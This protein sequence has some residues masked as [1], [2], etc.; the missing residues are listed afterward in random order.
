M[1][2]LLAGLKRALGKTVVGGGAPPVWCFACAAGKCGT[3]PR[4]GGCACCRAGHAGG[5]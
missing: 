1:R 2:K 5:S 3:V 4:D